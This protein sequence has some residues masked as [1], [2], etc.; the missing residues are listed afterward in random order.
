MPW[1][2]G[3]GLWADYMTGDLRMTGARGT[4]ALANPFPF[5]RQRRN[6]AIIGVSTAL[7]QPIGYATGRMGKAQIEKL[8]EILKELRQR[9]FYRILLIH[10]PPL[11]GLAKPRKEL[12]DAPDLAAVLSSE[13]AELVLH[14]HNHTD[15][16]T[17]LASPHGPVHIVGTASASANGNSRHPAAS[18]YLYD[19]RRQDGVWRCDVKV[20][21]YRPESGKLSDESQFSLDGR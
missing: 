9:G 11:P 6:V 18:W 13:G 4:A 21:R 8:A 16:R 19:I 5:V 17:S 2:Q 14:G 20:R 15:S 10:H 3:L 1:D 12:L 7:P